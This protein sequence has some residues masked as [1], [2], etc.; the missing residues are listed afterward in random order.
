MPALPSVGAGLTLLEML[1]TLAITAI[2][3]TLGFQLFAH[4]NRLETLLA[5]SRLEGS[6]ETVYREWLRQTLAGAQPERT[7]RPGQFKGQADRLQGASSV[8]PSAIEGGGQFL[9]TLGFNP[10]TGRSELRYQDERT[11]PT[12][13]IGWPGAD[14]RFH[15]QDDR[16]TL[17][18][19]WPPPLGAQQT[20]PRAV[21]IHGAQSVQPL[22]V[23]LEHSAFVPPRRADLERGL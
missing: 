23:P 14:A 2:V 8:L 11:P 17:H 19:S 18:D 21:F 15:Y 20:I 1:V 10:D 3:S 4:L 12:L 6:S 5:D 9:L 13:L 16:G 7:D 22:V